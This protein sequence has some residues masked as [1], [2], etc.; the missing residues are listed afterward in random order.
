MTIDALHYLI[1]MKSYSIRRNANQSK[2]SMLWHTI[3]TRGEP[4]TTIILIRQRFKLIPNY[5][6]LC[7]RAMPL[8]TLIQEV[9]ICSKG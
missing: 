3:V 2:I 6:L 9:S 4:T 8:S 1:G 5:L 7:Y